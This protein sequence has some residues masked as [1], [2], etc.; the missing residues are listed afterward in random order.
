MPCDGD[1]YNR[2]S[3][4]AWEPRVATPG[5]T[6]PLQSALESF[7][8]SGFVIGRGVEVAVPSLPHNLIACLAPGRPFGTEGAQ[9]VLGQIN[10][11]SSLRA[12]MAVVR[13]AD[14][15]DAWRWVSAGQSVGPGVRFD[16]VMPEPALALVV[17]RNDGIPILLAASALFSVG[18]VLFLLGRRRLSPVRGASTMAST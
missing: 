2:L 9:W 4:I 17:R 18:L 6:G 10:T 11:H 7:H 3:E 12:P 5:A 15:P 13:Q 1:G 8:R 14:A 16:G